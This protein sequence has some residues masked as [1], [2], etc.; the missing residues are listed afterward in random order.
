[1]LT[2]P[3]RQPRILFCSPH[4]LTRQLGAPKVLIELADEL[5]GLGW[6][7]DLLQPADLGV[8]RAG[9]PADRDR[10][11]ARLRDYLTEHGSDYD[12]L[13]VD[14]EDLPY[15]RR[16]FPP[17]T[18]V[19]ARS[20][21]LVQHLG[22]VQIPRPRGMRH[23]VGR[24]LHGR[25]RS[26]EERSRI[27]RG[28]RTVREADLV[29]VSNRRDRDELTRRGVPHEKVV[30]L[31]FG[32][33]AAQ[34]ALLE[35]PLIEPSAPPTVVFVGTFD[36]RKGALDFPA[37]VEHVADRV[38][39]V[40]F[41]LLGTAGLFPTADAVRYAFPRR[42]QSR[43][44]IHPR[45]RPDELASLLA[46]CSVGV[47]PSYLEGFGFGVL[48]MLAAGIPVIAYDAPGPGEMLG[49][50]Y[51]VPPGDALGMASR[52][53]ELLLDRTALARARETARRT[54]RE[55]S[56]AAIARATA[57]TYVARRAQRLAVPA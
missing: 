42:L 37:I 21:L 6:H 2:V 53:A 52:V 15:D 24:L 39:T 22:T 28:D 56:W 26:A 41:R 8:Q 50:E 55:F 20:V 1:M 40:R 57:D 18:L 46:G 7:C 36:Y 9:A 32:I 44:E 12:V 48:E 33:P 34:H 10:Y 17:D 23:A 16:L 54:A 51:L 29:N 27:A 25:E 3:A 5:R 14:H 38:P 11:T 35:E 43:L 47:F 31:P 49:P 4:P 45:F 13:D 30:V 19:V